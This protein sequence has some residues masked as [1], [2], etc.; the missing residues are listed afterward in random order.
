MATRKTKVAS[1]TSFKLPA[2]L[3]PDSLSGQISFE[4]S[5]QSPPPSAPISCPVVCIGASA[6]GLDAFTQ[7]LQ[8]LPPNTGMAFILIQHL[9]PARP[10]S[11]TEILARKTEMPVSQITT[12][13]AVA[14]NHIYVIPPN[15]NL[16]IYH[17]VLHLMPR[18]NL[19]REN[20]PIDYFM[21]SLA[22]DQ[23]NKAIGVIL[24]GTAS[25]GALGL[26][27]I[28]AGG[29]ITFAQSPETAEYDGMPRHAIAAGD[30]DFVLPPPEIAKELAL[31]GR[32]PY[33]LPV[34]APK[35]DNLFF[36]DQDNLNRIFSLLRSVTGADF[37]YYKP[38]TLKRRIMRR[39]VLHNI[40]G[41]AGY[42]KYLQHNPVEIKAL[43]QDILI[44][45][46]SFFR[47]P[48]S[49]EQLKAVAF[50]NLIKNKPDNIPLRIWAPGCSTGEEAYS[51]AIVLLEF[52]EEQGIKR[53][54]QIFATDLNGAVIEKARSG[55]YPESIKQDVTPERLRRFFNKVS[56]SYQISKAVRDLCIFAEQNV[57]KDP[58]FSRLDL[59]SCRN[60]LI[61]FGPVI[62]RKVIP[63]FHY[64][65][66]PTG[67]LMLG[68]SESVGTF[69]DLFAL[70]DKQNK[71]YAKKAALTPLRFDFAAVE[72]AAT[73]LE[74]Y[75]EMKNIRPDYDVLKEAD[76]I[77]LA[78]YVPA[79]ILVND[80]LEIL[81]FRGRTDPYLSHSP[82]LASFNLFK[83]TRPDLSIELHKAIHQAGKEEGPV[84]KGGLQINDDGQV[85]DLN[86]EVFPLKDPVQEKNYFLIVFEEVTLSTG[87]M[88]DPTRSHPVEPESGIHS[89]EIRQ[90]NQLKKEL[91][92]T[93]EYQ[94]SIIEQREAA[95]EELRAA[96][97]EIQSSNEELQSTHEEMETAKEELQATNEE[98]VTVNEEIRNRNAEVNLV[99][100]DL[101][102]LLSSTNI[103]IVILGNDL[104]IRRFTTMA[105]KVM[106]LIPTD[107]GRPLSDIR[108]NIELPQ[109]EEM[110][111][112]V[113]DTLAIR[114]QEVQDRWGRWY[115]LCIR[116]YKTFD[117]K[118]D[119]VVMT[120]FDIN[121]LKPNLDQLQE[122]RDYM[123][124]LET[125]REPFLILD[126][127]FRVK[128]A[129][130]AFCRTFQV[131]PSE[132]E[133]QV[134]FSLGN[135]QWDIPML[136]ALLEEILPKNSSFHDFKVEHT[137]PKIGHRVMLLNARRIVGEGHLTPFISLAFEDVTGK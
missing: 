76:Q 85:R 30:V 7:I 2:G 87:A 60:V 104:R 39:M 128:L 79:S 84:R 99:N 105:E 98:L 116:P 37:S 6:G 97:E 61:Y 101:S 47:E 45:V 106:N 59:I 131:A 92:A 34:I 89:D 51:L 17:G 81:Q 119:G 62:Q 133:N 94:Q 121:T 88:P 80:K 21:H 50:P 43:S 114:E 33:L 74:E 117:N 100:N 120:L 18:E 40:A 103:P 78:Q 31:I 53:S 135:G 96:N 67:Y 38:T 93:I 35:D 95:N 36:P 111:R 72:D 64:A 110:I 82:G 32:H 56:G 25:D 52:L 19:P 23:G 136:R 57:I 11:L 83:M 54:I 69:L 55:I 118:I 112:E 22:E 24:S 48:D 122:S 58:P 126:A 68:T 107:V 27:A 5:G 20:L 14:P 71:I 113:I 124:I 127:G 15:T 75:K 66:N 77:L 10:S 70:M 26:K 29:G 8:N 102:N 90:L 109:L 13:L 130:Q 125:I 65:L 115:S 134:I 1:K 16:V 129:N 28:K 86:I 12:N 49:F 132:T 42:V 63:I 4:K 44:G 9:D 123:A 46:T 73:R 91:A 41:V 137:F 3:Q 108:S